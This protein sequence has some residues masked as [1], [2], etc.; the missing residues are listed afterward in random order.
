MCR[1]CFPG[2]VSEDVEKAS[3]AELESLY[4]VVPMGRRCADCGI[5]FA[6]YVKAAKQCPDCAT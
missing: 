2:H 1:Q 4:S 5:V 3:A 6:T